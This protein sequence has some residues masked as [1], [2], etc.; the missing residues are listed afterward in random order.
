[1][2]DF[3][4]IFI[5]TFMAL[6]CSCK[7]YLDVVPDNVAT[8]DYAFR[9][10]ISAQKFL[11]TCYSYLPHIGNPTNDPAIMSSDEWWAHEELYYYQF[12]GNFDA[13]NI[14]RNRQN[15]NDPL[16]NYWQ[17]FRQGTD[18]YQGIRDCNIFL[19][20]VHKVGPDLPEGERRR[21][22][23]EVKFLKAYFHYYLLRMYGPV[24]LIKENFPIDTEV[25]S[26][27]IFR[28]PFD[29]CV[30]FIG[31]LINEAVPDLPLIISDVTNELG[32]ITQPI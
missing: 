1:M 20:N 4:Y 11:F 19:E 9:D 2:K 23:A 15:V 22:T 13:F 8:I 14:K 18:L 32:R 3:R 26:I 21:W 28:S 10:R 30:S 24:P 27:R 7:E 17:G 29:E 16:L 31:D 6:F 12:V 5:L 25:E